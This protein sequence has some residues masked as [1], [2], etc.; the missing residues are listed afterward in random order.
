MPERGEK[1]IVLTTRGGILTEK[2]VVG[3]DVRSAEAKLVDM[4]FTISAVDNNSGNVI[5]QAN[6]DGQTA[7]ISMNETGFNC[8]R[9]PVTSST[10]QA[11]C[12]DIEQVSQG[13]YLLYAVPFT[14]ETEDDL[15]YIGAFIGRETNPDLL[16]SKGVTEYAGC[17]EF[18]LAAPTLG[19]SEQLSGPMGM[20]ANF[21]SGVIDGYMKSELGSIGFDD[22][23]AGNGFTGE[24]SIVSM[25][26]KACAT[27][28]VS[29]Q[30]I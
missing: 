30:R 29:T 14:S 2:E 25:R 21:Q 1:P 10:G 26:I 4:E 6:V 15:S 28:S 13:L 11:Y 17:F 5:I 9:G 7:L 23:I 20:N 8:G 12:Y 16:S 18:L 22:M 3:L 27:L 19:F 24:R